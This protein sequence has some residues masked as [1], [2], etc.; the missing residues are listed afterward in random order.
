MLVANSVDGVGCGVVCCAVLPCVY[1]A[2]FPDFADDKKCNDG[3][4]LDET[5]P[6]CVS[7]YTS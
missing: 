3:V 6:L 2:V 7:G 5:F 1:T 4:T